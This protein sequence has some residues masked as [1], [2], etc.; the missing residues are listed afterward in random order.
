[1]ELHFSN[2]KNIV[3]LKVARGIIFLDTAEVYYGDV[4]EL[5]LKVSFLKEL[6]FS[7]NLTSLWMSFPR[8]MRM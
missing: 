4:N 6:I 3:E 2:T 7:Q 1:M 8:S 5:E